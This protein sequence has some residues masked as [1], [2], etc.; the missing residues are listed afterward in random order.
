M[1]IKLTLNLVTCFVYK[2]MHVVLLRQFMDFSLQICLTLLT[3]E[4]GEHSTVIQFVSFLWN[5]MPSFP[6]NNIFFPA[7]SLHVP[8]DT[9]SDSFL[10]YLDNVFSW[11]L[12]GTLKCLFI[13]HGFEIFTFFHKCSFYQTKPTFNVNYW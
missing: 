5:E 12:T 2:F 11:K 7:H 3:G 1:C 8:A 9:I 6:N 4:V 13:T 10:N